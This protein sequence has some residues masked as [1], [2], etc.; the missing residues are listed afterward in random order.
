MPSAVTPGETVSGGLRLQCHLTLVLGTQ[1][2]ETCVTPS[3][4]S[5]ELTLAWLPARLPVHTVSGCASLVHPPGLPSFGDEGVPLSSFGDAQKPYARS[6]W[7]IG[8]SG[9]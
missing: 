4:C 1:Q 2:L 6:T 8:N 7:K 5:E 3:C 9:G